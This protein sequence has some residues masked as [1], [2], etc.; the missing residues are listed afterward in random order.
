MYACIYCFANF[1]RKDPNQKIPVLAHYP[2]HNDKPIRVFEGGNICLYLSER[3]G[4]AFLP[5]D[6]RGRTECLNWVFW[7]QAASPSIGGG[8]GHFFHY[9]PVHIEYAIERYSIEVLRIHDVLD[10][11]LKQSGGP[12]ILGNFF[13]I[14]D[15][16]CAPWFLAI[17][18][19][20]VGSEEFLNLK[21]FQHIK[22]WLARFVQRPAVKR[23]LMVNGFG[24]K[25]VR[26]RHSADDLI[27]AK[28]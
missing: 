8:F 5:K 1:Q 14:A 10:R 22:Q 2:S 17:P 12:W 11:Q 28:L 7:L 26:E 23:G 3:H 6:I 9:A 19:G 21:Q 18:R 16:V 24:Q 25:A 15:I 20:Y 13:S 27:K 4:S